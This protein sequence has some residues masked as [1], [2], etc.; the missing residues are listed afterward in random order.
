[1]IMENEIRVSYH[2]TNDENTTASLA[3][4]RIR[5][6]LIRLKKLEALN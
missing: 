1:M 5:K 2:K 6:K 3:A 4:G